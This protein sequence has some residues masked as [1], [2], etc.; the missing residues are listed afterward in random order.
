[1]NGIPPLVTRKRSRTHL[2]LDGIE[3]V[4]RVGA[5]RLAY[6]V[7][8]G[9]T[10]LTRSHCTTPWHVL[11]PAYLDDTG[12]AYTQLVNPSG[13]LVGGDRLS[14]ELNL[15]KGAHVLISTPSANRVYRSEEKP[16]EQIV[17]ITVGSGAILE[18][19]PEQTIP[20][21]GS[22]FRQIIRVQLEPG[23]TIMLWDV[24]AAGRIARGERWAFA[25]LENDVHI[26]TT[27]GG[28]L[29]ERYRLDPSTDLG[30]VGLAEAWNYVA[31]LYMVGDSI[32]PEAWNRLESKA[33]SLLDERPG[34]VLGGVSTPAVPGL[35]VKLLAKA[36]PDLNRIFDALWTAVRL[37][38]WNLPA[39]SLRKY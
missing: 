32:A 19:L 6:G 37:E 15:D 30:Q 9:R 21:A 11:P 18:W 27:S 35:A 10:I 34:Q 3:A 23:A 2:G 16:S 14:I 12:A 5:L 31:S 24:V 25:A 13:G 7:R 39:V 29:L 38:L 1:M 26:T 28:A 33:A 8:D 17:T 4:G 20:F 36:A 22:R